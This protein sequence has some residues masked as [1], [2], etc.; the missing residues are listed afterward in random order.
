MWSENKWLAVAEWKKITFVE[1]GAS[2]S[3]PSA[4]SNWNMEYKIQTSGNRSIFVN[5][6]VESD[7]RLLE[8][9]ADRAK[10]SKILTHSVVCSTSLCDSFGFL[11]F[12]AIFEKNI[13]THPIVFLHGFPRSCFPLLAQSDR[14]RFWEH[15]LVSADKGTW[16]DIYSF[17]LDAFF[18]SLWSH[19]L[20]MW[21]MSGN[22]AA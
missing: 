11:F 8:K 9:S 10:S 17:S 20:Q 5:F 2:Y 3:S 1:E 18:S 19:F 13:V 16:T 4:L 6:S 14:R 22:Q 21:L 12:F 15:L 7:P